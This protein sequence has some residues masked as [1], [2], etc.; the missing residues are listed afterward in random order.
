MSALGG[1]STSCN[2]SQPLQGPFSSWK[3][4]CELH[5]I[6]LKS[7]PQG[8][9]MQERVTFRGQGKP[10]KQSSCD[11][12]PHLFLPHIRERIW[13]RRGRTEG[14]VSA[15]RWGCGW[16]RSSP[17][18]PTRIPNIWR[19]SSHQDGFRK[20]E[21][22]TSAKEAKARRSELANHPALR[23]LRFYRPTPSPSHCARNSAAFLGL[24]ISR[25]PR[26]QP[27]R[28]RHTT[29]QR[30]RLGIGQIWRRTGFLGG[31][32]M[33]QESCLREKRFCTSQCP[34]MG[35]PWVLD[36]DAGTH[37][38]LGCPWVKRGALGCR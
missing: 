4:K 30:P 33:G 7:A 19:C 35:T 5:S 31:G 14:H 15:G 27:R 2:P 32:G 25:H 13:T 17:R 34:Q 3:A 28:G 11:A 36:E 37:P 29:S 12:I 6:P 38:G 20:A 26:L 8:V 21:S 22:P 1:R 23:L 9:W 24:T 16:V 10:S 18:C